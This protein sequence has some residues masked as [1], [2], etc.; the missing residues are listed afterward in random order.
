MQSRKYRKYL[1]D[2]KFD[3]LMETEKSGG[4]KEEVFRVIIL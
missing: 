4:K 1:F 2:L 3:P